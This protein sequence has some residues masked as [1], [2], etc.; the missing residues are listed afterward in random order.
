[1]NEVS[2]KGGERQLPHSACQPATCYDPPV[3]HSQHLSPDKWTSIRTKHIVS[4]EKVLDTGLLFVVSH[5]ECTV[6]FAF[7]RS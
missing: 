5:S 2:E 6:F 1:M 4:H 3:A 7:L